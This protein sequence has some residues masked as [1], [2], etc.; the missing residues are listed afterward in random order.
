MQ[1]YSGFLFLAALIFVF[2]VVFVWAGGGAGG[3]FD[4]EGVGRGVCGG[5]GVGDRGGVGAGV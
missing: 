2:F 3:V 1:S 5:V 4:F